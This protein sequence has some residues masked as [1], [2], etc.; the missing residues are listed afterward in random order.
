[1]EIIISIYS[2]PETGLNA[3][4]IISKINSGL[5]I[6]DKK[7]GTSYC[8]LKNFYTENEKGE[9]RINSTKSNP[10]KGT[11][12]LEINNVEDVPNLIEKIKG[13][14]QAVVELHSPSTTYQVVKGTE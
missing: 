1:M 2:K 14:I 10:K 6:F 9:L 4:E 11:S 7:K 8:C 5:L 3:S 13:K 12:L